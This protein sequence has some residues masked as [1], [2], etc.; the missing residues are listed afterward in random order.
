MSKSQTKFPPIIQWTPDCALGLPQIDGEHERF[1][2]LLE[3]LHQALLQGKAKPVLDH[4]LTE[5]IDYTRYHFEHEEELMRRMRYPGYRE[6]VR[7]H[8]K[9]RSKTHD[10]ADRFSRG[11]ITITIATMQFLADWLKRHRSMDRRFG[12][13][14][15]MRGVSVAP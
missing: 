13:Y 5:M 8:E 7:E 12:D 4:L 15:A 11:E 14:A 1:F 3:G 10:L 2:S 9:L 6:H